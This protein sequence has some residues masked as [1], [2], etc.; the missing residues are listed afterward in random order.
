MTT[1]EVVNSAP[2]PLPEL[3][4]PVGEYYDWH[5]RDELRFQWCTECARWM[6]P[7]RH[8]CPAAPEHAVSWCAVRGTG[9]IF[10]Y[11]VT[12][13]A[14]H[15]SFTDTPYTCAVVQLDEGVRILARLVDDDRSDVRIGAPVRVI[16]V[17]VQPGTRIAMFTTNRESE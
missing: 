13:R 2:H 4:G 14:L 7:P 8:D 9:E 17:E 1:N 16:F 6:H 5:N 15:P 11:V 12:H 10:S 3:A